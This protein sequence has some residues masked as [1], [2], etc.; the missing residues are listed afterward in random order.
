MDILGSFLEI[1]QGVIPIIT[2][3]IGIYFYI[4]G[5]KDKNTSLKKDKVFQELERLMILAESMSLS[6]AN[7]KK[8]VKQ[9]INKFLNEIKLK[10]T[11]EQLGIDNKI[12]ELVHLSNNLNK[13]G[14]E[15]TASLENKV[16]NLQ[17]LLE[18]E[19]EINENL[20]GG[21]HAGE[22]ENETNH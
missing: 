18:K 21:Q 20:R 8:F 14:T 3:V 2:I 6:G 17:E 19:Q 16:K 7:K 5:Y 11:P 1:V 15:S 13:R 10:E 4:I 12:E 9:A 22:R